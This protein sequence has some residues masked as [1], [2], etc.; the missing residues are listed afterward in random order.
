[1][2]R[3]EMDPGG[4]STAGDD[5][6]DTANTAN[7][8][9]KTLFSSSDKAA[10]DNPGW[11]AA[12]ALTTVKSA[13]QDQFNKLVRQTVDA[14][15]ALRDSAGQVQATDQEAENRLNNVMHDVAGE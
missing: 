3:I 11:A 15:D 2:G 5:L 14:A 10:Q 1:M 6:H 7:T 13:W 12:A 4:V 8:R 9:T